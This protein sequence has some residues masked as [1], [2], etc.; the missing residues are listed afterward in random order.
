MKKT[1]KKSAKPKPV[2]DFDTMVQRALDAV[3]GLTD[4]EVRHNTFRRVLGALV[5]GKK[6]EWPTSKATTAGSSVVF[7]GTGP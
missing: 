6:K 4:I 2:G 7:D 1:K 3:S 5:A